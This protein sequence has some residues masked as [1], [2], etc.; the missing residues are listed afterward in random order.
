MKRRVNQNDPEYQGPIGLS[1]AEVERELFKGRWNNGGYDAAFGRYIREM[2]NPHK[3]DCSLWP[4]AMRLTDAFKWRQI[5]KEREEKGVS[6]K[7][8]SAEEQI[9]RLANF[10]MAEVPGEPSQSQGA[11]DTAIRIIRLRGAKP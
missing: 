4:E 7:R 11:V 10:I 8:E 9:D 2:G 5:D 6:Q 3:S 1:R